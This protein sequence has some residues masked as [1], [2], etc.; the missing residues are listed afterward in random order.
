[1]LCIW[2]VEAEYGHGTVAAARMGEARRRLRAS[3]TGAPPMPSAP[4]P[5]R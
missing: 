5:L 4:L 1:M 2:S 3:L